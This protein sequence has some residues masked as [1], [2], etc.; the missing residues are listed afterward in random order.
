MKSK[1]EEYVRICPKCNSIDVSDDMSNPA[2]KY[3]GQIESMVCNNCGFTGTIFPE[4]KRS[5]KPDKKNDEKK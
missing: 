5:E 1:R 3:I 4:V 2:I